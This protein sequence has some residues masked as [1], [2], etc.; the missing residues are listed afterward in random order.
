[1][2]DFYEPVSQLLQRWWTVSDLGLSDFLDVLALLDGNQL[3]L[4]IVFLFFLVLLLY[5][6]EPLN[7]TRRWHRILLTSKLFKLLDLSFCGRFQI[8]VKELFLCSLITIF[9]EDLYA[10]D[11]LIDD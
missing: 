8:E 6:G 9:H 2:L 1:M 7:R 5:S 4:H 11:R 3:S 10:S